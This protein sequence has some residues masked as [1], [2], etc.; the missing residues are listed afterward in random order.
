[1]KFSKNLFLIFSS[2]YVIA[3]YSCK[4]KKPVVAA[5]IPATVVTPAP[6]EKPAETT[7]V[8][9]VTPA[10]VVEKPNF[11]ISN[12][13]FEFNSSVLKTASLP[14]LETAVRE[15]KKAPNTKF[16]LNGHSS[17]EGTPAHN[18][19]LSIDRANAVKTFFVNA[20][21]AASNFTVVGHGEKYPVSNNNTEAGR[22]LNR[23]TEIQVVE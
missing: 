18:L 11:N 22:I 16:I 14:I 23:R 12:I 5:P 9:P 4:A 2:L 21:L 15:M 20:G 7:T 3:L 19:K 6:A 10:P 17:A 1:M 8:T 13:Q